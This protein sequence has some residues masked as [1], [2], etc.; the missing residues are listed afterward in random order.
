MEFERAIFRVYERCIEGLR[1]EEGETESG[2]NSKSCKLFEILLCITATFF[3]FILIFLHVS[4]VGSAGCLNALLLEK[5]ISKVHYDEVLI[6]NVDRRFGLNVDNSGADNLW[7]NN[8]DD[9]MEES[10]AEARM[11]KSRLLSDDPSSRATPSCRM[12]RNWSYKNLLGYKAVQDECET[13]YDENH[14]SSLFRRKHKPFLFLD[15]VIACVGRNIGVNSIFHNTHI[16]TRNLASYGGNSTSNITAL[17]FNN[18]SHDNKGYRYI[19]DYEFAFD[20]GLLAMRDETR[21]KHNINTVNVTLSGE[22]CFGGRFL[23]TLLPLGGMDTLVINT[24]MSTVMEGGVLITSSGDYYMWNDMDT[25][26]IR[27]FG[28]WLGTKIAIILLSFLSFFFIST[29]TALLVRV[30]ISSGVVILFPFF[31][32]IQWVGIANIINS[33]IIS[34]SYPWIGVPLEMLRARN[35]TTSPFI[36]SHVT[37]VI[38][39]YAFYEACQLAFSMWFYGQSRPGAR[40]MWIF[41]IMMLWEYY[42]MIYVRAAPTIQLFP[43]ASFALYLILHFYIYSFQFGFHL[44]AI[45][46]MFLY[47]LS[48]MIH[49]VRKYEID[50]YYRGIVNID[51]PRQFYNALPWPTWNI[52]L[53]PDYTVFLPLSHRSVPV[54]QMT[55]PDVGHTTNN[56]DTASAAGDNPTAYSRVVQSVS[57]L[58]S[59]VTGSSNGV[60]R[61]HGDALRNAPPEGVNMIQTPTSVHNTNGSA[62]RRVVYSR[63]EEGQET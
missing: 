56:N 16:Y 29:T 8:E 44:L 45:L 33:R 25:R 4:F 48:L 27:S 54:Y 47:L 43:R 9:S 17:I 2:V 35:Q 39:Y 41:A 34:L 32:F 36:I 11:R 53:A 3:L 30:L 19:Y 1:D 37:R 60:S 59:T 21:R 46:V 12:R 57:S 55:P 51:Q 26:K 61:N 40:E 28:Q 23:Q 20:I 50:V 6:V 31:W 22:Q 18:T 15:R 10:T 7:R 49:C 24:V 58:L 42:S 62:T 38:I 14:P 52:S 13:Y 5:N 63:I